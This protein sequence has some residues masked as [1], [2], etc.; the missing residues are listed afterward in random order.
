MC[1]SG[2]RS[3]AAAKIKVLLARDGVVPRPVERGAYS[4]NRV[5]LEQEESLLEL[6][7]G[8]RDQSA[9]RRSRRRI[10]RPQLGAHAGQRCALTLQHRL[11]V[12]GGSEQPEAD[13]E[14]Q[15][16]HLGGEE[17]GYLKIDEPEVHQ[18][19]EYGEK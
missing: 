4:S 14:L 16:V 9:F 15:R 3:G 6:T 11:S 10:T 2:Q 19:L 8:H 12:A 7:D 5:A 18:L 13:V 1:A 17:L